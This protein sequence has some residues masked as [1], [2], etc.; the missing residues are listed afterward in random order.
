MNDK[1]SN[2][3][4]TLRELARSLDCFTESELQTLSDATPNTVEAWRKRRT[5]PPY[6][7]FGRRYLYPRKAVADFLHAKVRES[8]RGT[9][10]K[11][12]L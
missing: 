6:I 7:L 4:A 5:G 12:V 9:P 8:G 3:E 11:G 10:A 1:V 2:E